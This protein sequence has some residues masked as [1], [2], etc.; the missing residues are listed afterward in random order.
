MN[1][2]IVI[3][4]SSMTVAHLTAAHGIVGVTLAWAELASFFLSFQLSRKEPLIL[5][6]IHQIP[7]QS[8]HASSLSDVSCIFI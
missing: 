6:S 7:A 1:G 5:F 4:A 8:P 2:I 3:C